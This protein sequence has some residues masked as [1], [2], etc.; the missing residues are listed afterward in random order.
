MASPWKF[1]SRF[2]PGR[3]GQKQDDGKVVHPK[4][5]VLAIAGPSGSVA[6][7]D[8][9]S[10]DPLADV[11]LPRPDPSDPVSVEHE[12]VGGAV[13]EAGEKLDN[14]VA[15][16]VVDGSAPSDN[17]DL[18]V[19]SAPDATD[20]HP[21]VEGKAR[22]PRPRAKKPEPVVVTAQVSLGVDTASDDT[23]SLDEEIRVLRG[24]LAAKLQLQNAQLRKMLER[25]ER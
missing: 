24:Q 12:P 2:V 5:D 19:T 10:E 25:F 13:E 20:L 9:D 18:G 23:I 4:P 6:E 15:G 22:K 14:V 8:F 1:L 17:T 3:R 7:E 16:I 21:P 11:E